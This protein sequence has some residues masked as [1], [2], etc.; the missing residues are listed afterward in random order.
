[1]SQFVT[2]E[3]IQMELAKMMEKCRREATQETCQ[4]FAANVLAAI[5][6]Q[7]SCR[8]ESVCDGRSPN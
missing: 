2:E 6:K 1:M 7:H 5:S 3:D 4:L 8:V